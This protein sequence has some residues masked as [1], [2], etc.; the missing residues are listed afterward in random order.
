LPPLADLQRDFLGAVLTGDAAA[1]DR[2]G[3][4]G[5]VDVVQALRLHRDTVFGALATCLRLTFPTVDQLVGEAFFDQAALAF[6]TLSP[7][8]S[9]NLATYGEDFPRFLVAYEGARALAYLPDVARLDWAISAAHRGPDE[10]RRRNLGIDATVSLSV[11]AELNLFAVDH[12]A[13]EIRDALDAEDEAAL[14][15]IDLQPHPHFIAVWRRGDLAVSRRLAAP[16]GRFLA[17]LLDG[18]GSDAALEAAVAETASADA[19]AA[20]QSDVFS[21]SFAQLSPQD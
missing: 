4:R 10:T 5:A 7:P 17:L 6:A 8:R 2:L 3:L 12:P 16:A 11:P 21:A 14:T 15:A 19:L 18:R 9:A 20:I 1:A 13:S